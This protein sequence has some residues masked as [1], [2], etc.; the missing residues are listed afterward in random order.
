MKHPLIAVLVFFAVATVT[1]AQKGGENSGRILEGIPVESK[2]LKET[3]RY[4]VY[5]PPDSGSRLYPVLYLLHG[6]SDDHT[7]WTQFGEVARIA[8]EAIK[9]GKATP[10]IIVMPDA[11][12]TFYLN[13][14]DGSYP[15]EDYFFQ[16]LIP[17]IEKNPQVRR[18]KEFR[19]VAGLSMGGFGTLVYALK[20]GD[21]FAAA[22]PLSAAVFSDA[23]INRMPHDRYKERFTE[24]LGEVPK[25]G[26]DRIT[27]DWK[28]NSPEHL[29]RKY[30]E[31]AKKLAEDEK[32]KRLEG[33]ALRKAKEDLRNRAVRFY[34]D[35]GDDDF[36]YAG[37][38]WLPIWM[39]EAKIPVEYRVRDGGHS[40]QYWREALPEVLA[41]VS[42]SFHR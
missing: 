15:Y 12:R 10:M 27:E 35:C 25:E 37:N 8:D 41:F 26:E 23:D 21:M 28:A 39:K 17:E 16:E 1:F 22:C 38:M 6:Y 9:S 34:I 31:D 30:A 42:R 19:A 4:S 18:G 29:I 5:L 32:E 40:W 36:L 13:K 3:M 14:G 2:I 11:K 7:A 20:H 24:F 33:D